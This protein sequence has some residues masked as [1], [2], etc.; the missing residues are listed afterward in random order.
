VPAVSSGGGRAT[1]RS[2]PVAWIAAGTAVVV[3]GVLAWQLGQRSAGPAPAVPLAQAPAPMPAPAPAPA[4]TPVPPAA[5]APAPAPMAKPAPAPAR[6]TP[7]PSAAAPTPR[8]EPAPRAAARAPAQAA[9][10]P[11]V[12]KRVF[13]LHELP[14]DVRNRLPKL[15]IGGS[16]Y[17]PDRSK[18]FLIVNGQ[19][20]KEKDAVTPEVTLEEIQLRA[21]VLRYQDYRYGITY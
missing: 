2:L 13:A 8:A 5:V 16:R 15:S 6:A 18:R 9:V 11:A 20:L 4:P 14:E 3:A 1:G 12:D 21:A 19:M 17:S 10:P 7:R